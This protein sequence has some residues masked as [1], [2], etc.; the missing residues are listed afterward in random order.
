M[1]DNK[2]IVESIIKQFKLV[3]RDFYYLDED[4]MSKKQEKI[5]NDILDMADDLEKLCRDFIV[6]E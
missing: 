5:F 6:A 1:E 4:A 2:K 3:R